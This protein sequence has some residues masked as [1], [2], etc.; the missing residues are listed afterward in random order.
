MY[1]FGFR[2]YTLSCLFAWFCLL[3]IV[4]ISCWVVLFTDFVIL[5]M[6]IAICCCDVLVSCFVLILS[7]LFWFRVLF[8]GLF[9]GEL[10][11]VFQYC[12]FYCY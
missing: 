4:C 12:C 2:V 5:V 11:F 3:C 7:L 1:D 9:Y 8:P 6:M 10:L